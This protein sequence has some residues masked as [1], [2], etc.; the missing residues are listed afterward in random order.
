MA[1]VSL[2]KVPVRLTLAIHGEVGTMT[3]NTDAILALDWD[4]TITCHAAALSIMAHRFD[5]VVIVTMND[6]VTAKM[7]AAAL[8]FPEAKIRVE[9][10]PEDQSMDFSG[11]ADW[12]ARTCLS[13]DVHLM[14]DDDPGVVA[15]CQRAGVPALLVSSP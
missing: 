14:I 10:C 3:A 12:K 6:T 4:G 7:A 1:S 8:S 13:H 2:S 5:R 11:Y 9:I 15:A